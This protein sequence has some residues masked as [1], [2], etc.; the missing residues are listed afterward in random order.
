M[1]IFSRDLALLALGLAAGGLAC[2]IVYAI[3]WKRVDWPATF[4]ATSNIAQVIALI[5][6]AVWTYRLFVRQR[7]NIVRVNIEHVVRG[8]LLQN[9]Q[10]L[11]RVVMEIHNLGTVLLQ[12][13]KGSLS[14]YAVSPST[15]GLIHKVYESSETADKNWPEIKNL[16]I[17]FAEDN[18]RL[19]PGEKERYPYDFIVPSSLEIVQIHSSVWC[20]DEDDPAYFRDETTI[21][22]F[23]VPDGERNPEEKEGTESKETS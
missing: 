13:T 12:P 3:A 1:K 10:R 20:G 21:H 18:F 6:G 23:T 7:S 5:V 14:I 17:N 2:H 9:D 16:P 4:Q 15:K 19:E 8:F 11:I 22:K